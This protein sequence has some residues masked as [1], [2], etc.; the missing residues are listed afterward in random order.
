MPT[1]HNRYQAALY[2]CPCCSTFR[3]SKSMERVWY[4]NNCYNGKPLQFRYFN[5]PVSKDKR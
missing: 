5:L 3:S 2:F 1:Y 4:W